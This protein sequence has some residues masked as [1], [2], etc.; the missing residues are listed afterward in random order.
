M[1]DQTTNPEGWTSTST[2]PETPSATDRVGFC[3]DCGRPLTAAT[4]RNIGTGVFCEPCLNLR[5][6]VPNPASGYTTVPPYTAVP[7]Y[8][9][10]PLADVP[11][12]VLAGILGFIPGVGAM[13]NGQ[14]AKG[15]VHVIIFAILASI[16]DNHD[17]FGFLVAG[18]EFYMAF[19]AYHTA[20][21]RLLGLPLPNPFGFN[22]I[23][24]RMG[25][26]KSW[27]TIPTVKV[28]P[29]GTTPPPDPSAP[30]TPGYIPYVQAAATSPDWVGYV[31][32]SAFAGNVAQQQAASE[33]MAA[34]IREQALRDAG[35]YNQP[36]YAPTYAPNPY[37]A[38]NPYT[39]PVAPYTANVPPVEV[40]V[41]KR[42]FPVG[43]FWLIGLGLL[44][45]LASVIPD[46]EMSGRWWPPIL[47]AGLASWIFVRRLRSGTRII[48]IVRWPL[49]L[50]VLAIMLALHAAHVNVTFGL[51]CAVLLI[52]FGA[53]LLLER[54]L[55]ASPLYPAPATPAGYTSVV[56]PSEPEAPRAAWSEPSINTTDTPKEDHQS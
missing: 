7:P 42:R 45:L 16:A 41:G 35:Y 47:L 39:V 33:A 49:I 52:L 25:F 11:K 6:A 2:P 23:G 40:L 38:A 48:C 31:P 44:I 4:V 26:G 29:A 9:T 24:E 10:A 53:L 19:E 56:P 5:T 28:A 37:A 22:D 15:I 20:K 17:V 1:S 43:A 51:T 12:P 30:P 8:A 3:Q 21:A 36:A 14:F 13:Y 54:T 18:W 55:G 32:P 34:Q 50:M 46:W 27:G